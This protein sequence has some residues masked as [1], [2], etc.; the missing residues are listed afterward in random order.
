MAENVTPSLPPSPHQG[1]QSLWKRS[2]K[3]LDAKQ[4][5]FLQPLLKPSQ[6][7]T[8]FDGRMILV[9]AFEFCSIP[10]TC[11][12]LYPGR[13]LILHPT[14]RKSYIRS[15][16]IES[17]SLMWVMPSLAEQSIPDKS[18]KQGRSPSAP[19]AADP[20]RRREQV[21]NAQRYVL[22][23]ALRGH[24]LGCPAFASM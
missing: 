7:N 5:T 20:S 19:T 22:L 18:A 21:R 24:G 11:L 1:K 9:D 16:L 3:I 14:L 23:G 8:F 2:K 15:A 10:L 12:V 6:G 13:P 4:I 17:S